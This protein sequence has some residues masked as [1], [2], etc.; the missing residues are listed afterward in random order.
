MNSVTVPQSDD[1]RRRPI[2]IVGIAVSDLAHPN[3]LF[4]CTGNATRSV[5]GGAAL[6]RRRPELVIETAGTL[7]VDGLP[8]SWRT[9]AAFEDVGLELPRH[10]S[11]Q[12]EFAHVETADVIIAMGPEHIHWVRREHPEASA[13]AVSLVRLHRDLPPPR[14]P[15][16]HRLAA[17]S[18][19]TIETESWEEIVDPGGE[20]VEAFVACARRIVELI[21]DLADRL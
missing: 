14:S 15:L 1:G 3:V 5:L 7:T 11:R 13:R 12:A 17:M 16:I 4:L 9:R 19:G 2:R 18:L 6:A 8:M 20:E 10:A 21:D